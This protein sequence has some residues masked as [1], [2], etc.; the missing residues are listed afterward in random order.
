MQEL[1]SAGTSVAIIDES[2]YAQ[3]QDT[4]VPLIILATAGEKQHPFNATS[5]SMISTTASSSACANC[6]IGTYEHGVVRTI[7]S[8]RQSL[9]LYGIPRFL[10]TA[11][12]Q[13]RH[14]DARNEYGLLA[15]NHF[16]AQGR[17]AYVVRANVN[18]DD[19]IEGVVSMWSK[20]VD[21]TADLFEEL[22]REH[23]DNYNDLNGYVPANIASYKTTLTADEVKD[24]MREVLATRAFKDYSFSNINFQEEFTRDHGTSTA[25]YVEVQLSNTRGYIVGS[26][27]T[28]LDPLKTYQIN[29]GVNGLAASG[30][31]WPAAGDAISIQGVRTYDELVTALNTALAD[32]TFDD[33]APAGAQVVASLANG[34]L[35]FTSAL[36]GTTS[37]VKLTNADTTNPLFI[38]TSLPD[39]VE[40]LE[41][42]K[43]R[44]DQ[45]LAIYT[46]Y[47]YSDLDGTFEGLDAEIDLAA[48]V[49]PDFTI[50]AAIAVLTEA[51]A[52]YQLTREFRTLTSLG[53]A[54]ADRREKIV[55]AL[56]AEL[57][58]NDYIRNELYEHNL[59]LVPGYPEVG[60]ALDEFVKS[61]QIKEEVFVIGSV[62]MNVAADGPDGLLEWNT[63]SGIKS[64]NFAYYYP[65]PLMRNADGKMVMGCSTTVALR[66]IAYNDYVAEPWFA[67]AGM[68]RGGAPGVIDVG[69]ASGEMGGPT[70]FVQ[71]HLQEGQRDH[72]YVSN[73]NPIVFYPT[74]G[75]VVWGQ[76]TTQPFASAMDRVAVSRMTKYIQR[77]LRKGSLPFV[78]EQ[79]DYITREQLRA[80]VDNFLNI[81]MMRRGLYDYAVQCDRANNT[82]ERIDRNEMWV[83]VA[84]K[85]VKQ[86]EFIYIPVRVVNTGTDIGTGRTIELGSR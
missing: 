64:S 49:D 68:R 80:T 36:E 15:L 44:G 20:R 25:G 73:L 81:I 4:C 37:S 34:R 32:A 10:E 12:G 8:L 7:T 77:G 75:I 71:V 5:F 63:K 85:P 35:R 74:S 39:V 60:A 3:G 21:D 11:A 9:E 59:I 29:I 48:G 43:G 6:A 46:D 52:G 50:A 55:Q 40:I 41:P 33:Q 30:A 53:T 82:D 27:V 24:L 38:T 51:A 72:L 28:G 79:N 83:D 62:P 56:V 47:T 13:P 16:L 26:D 23:I 76:K 65:H 58:T 61:R 84:I 78:F 57:K 42:V 69:Y 1:V 67:P 66:T 18:L 45:G 54:D 31:P 19:S 14:G 70:E 86:A 22:A 17:R 2:M